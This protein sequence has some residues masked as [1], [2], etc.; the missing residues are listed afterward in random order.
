MSILEVGQAKIRSLFKPAPP[1]PLLPPVVVREDGLF[2]YQA[3]DL[4][5]LGSIPGQWDHRGAENVYLAHTDFNGLTALDVGPANG[6][7]SFEMERRGA[8]V[9]AIELGPDDDWDAVP[10]GGLPPTGASE[11]MKDCVEKTHADFLTCRSALKSSVEVRRGAAYAVPS[12]VERKDV[13][14]MGNI[15]QHLRDPLL[16]IERVAS[17]VKRRMIISETLWIHDEKFLNSAQMQL[18]PRSHMPEVNHSWYQ[19]SPVFV[20]EA[21]NILG[22]TNLKC[23]MH[24]Q[25]FNGTSV[26]PSPRMVRH[27]TVSAER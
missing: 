18:I 26:D 20:M 17:V 6:F 24:E 4:P 16:A 19:V 25:M 7:W 21:L 5:G 3:I 27:F 1:P 8:K 15:L 22:F 2:F 23:E 13:A 12:L 9:T 14:L 10:H 11:A